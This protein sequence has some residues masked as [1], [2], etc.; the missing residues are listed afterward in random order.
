MQGHAANQLNV[1]RNHFPS[2]GMASHD[3]VFSAETTAGLFDH[4]KGLGHDLLETLGQLHR[5]FDHRKFLFPGSSLFPELIIREI[6]H[7]LVHGVDLLDNLAVTTHFPI[8]CRSKK[9]FEYAFKGSNHG[10]LG[11]RKRRQW[12]TARTSDKK[13]KL[14]EGA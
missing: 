12:I 3:D 9:L 11:F 10:N 13:E 1:K 6:L 8:V 2:Q 14:G 5:I 7:G 4:R